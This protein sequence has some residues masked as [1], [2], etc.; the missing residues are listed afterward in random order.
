MNDL[1]RLCALS[2]RFGRDILLAQGS[3]GN[4]SVKVSDDRMWIKASG[5]RLDELAP[6]GLV[7]TD[8]GLLRREMTPLWSRD[9]RSERQ[10]RYADLM[11]RAARSPGR[12][13]LETSLHAL[14][15]ERWVIHL[16]S[17]AGMV[18]GLMPPPEAAA[19]VEEILGETTSLHRTPPAAP[20]FELGRA[21]AGAPPPSQGHREVSL[22]LLENHG[23]VWAAD[24]AD[25]L[26]HA[27]DRLESALRVRWGLDR[28]PFPAVSA[29]PETDAPAPGRW[30]R[31]SLDGW[32]GVDVDDQALIPDFAGHFD[33]W[34]GAT[35]NLLFRDR[36]TVW[37]RA[38]DER[39]RRGHTEVF[40]AHALAST[41]SR[42][43]GWFRALP[44]DIIRTVKEFLLEGPRY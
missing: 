23:L 8:L 12:V 10:N 17:V 15:P 33:L 4:T 5:G 9:D 2:R 13:S 3:G 30:H 34:F 20:G 40:F 36:R 1:P 7:E 6:T 16:H 26:A 14:L 25:V 22:W 43:H 44:L 37:I 28:Y 39:T 19:L 18:L 24:D 38:D 32:P 31:V 42:R 21:V 27:A 35:P 11:A 29:V 41:L